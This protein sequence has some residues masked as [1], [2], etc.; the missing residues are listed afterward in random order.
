MATSLDMLPT[1]DDYAR[2]QAI[3]RGLPPE[4][5]DVLRDKGLTFTEISELVIPPRTLKRRQ[6]RGENLSLEE[7]ERLLRVDRML[8]RA[9]ETFGE[10][11][12]QCAG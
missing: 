11:K 9:D 5:P 12:G 2:V 10:H 4:S 7:T 8:T 1:S 3:E 6:E